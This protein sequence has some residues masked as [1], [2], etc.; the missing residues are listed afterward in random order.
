MKTAAR[1][2]RSRRSLGARLGTYWL[3]GVVVLAAIAWGA[4]AAMR[5]PAFHVRSVAVSGLGRVAR[6]EVLARAAIEPDDNAWL[7]NRTAIRRRIEAIPYVAT[8]AVHV[9]PPG[10]VWIEVVER[11][12]DACVRDARGRTVTIDSALRVLE[13]GCSEAQLVYVLRDALDSPPGAFVRDEELAELENDAHALA[14]R[15]DRYREF[16][17]DP[18]GQLEGTLVEGIRVRFGDDDDL[19]RK[20]HLIGPILAQLGSRAG[21]VRAVD[22]RAPATPV[23]EYRH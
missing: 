19:D 17:H 13:N 9:A 15:G 8:A 4:V 11:Q 10:D 23:V 1:R 22:L 2:R 3:A 18:F 5:L 21:D 14:G 12:P 6:D 16:E 20:Q 7:L